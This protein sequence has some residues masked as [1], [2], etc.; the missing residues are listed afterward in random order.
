MKELQN[1]IK[2]APNG[3]IGFVCSL[4]MTLFWGLLIGLIINGAYWS[5]MGFKA[6]N[7][8]LNTTAIEQSNSFDGNTDFSSKYLSKAMSYLK[9]KEATALEYLVLSK[10]EMLSP[11]KP[12]AKKVALWLNHFIVVVFKTLEVLMLK[13]ASVFAS[14]WLY[15]FFALMGAI[16]GLLSRFIRT[17][18]GGRESTFLFHKISASMLKLPLGVL[19]LYLSLPVFIEPQWVVLVVGVLFFGF[20][21]LSTSNLKKFI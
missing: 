8:D 5:L 4:L 10:G 1:E 14:S 3:F 2:R 19:F 6:L 20:F 21:K 16:D 15:V 11:I 12:W 18:E 9:A 17:E 13:F 7:Q